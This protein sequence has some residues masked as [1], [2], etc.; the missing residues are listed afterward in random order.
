MSPNQLLDMVRRDVVQKGVPATSLQLGITSQK[1]L[2]DMN[3]TPKQMNIGMYMK[4]RN[5]YD[6]EYN[7]LPMT[8]KQ[9]MAL[10]ELGRL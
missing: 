1:M 8:K 9:D 2:Y 4:L 7:Q 3:Y 6:E 10:K 5:Y